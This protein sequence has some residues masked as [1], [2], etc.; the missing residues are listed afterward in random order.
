MNLYAFNPKNLNY[1]DSGEFIVRY[2][3]DIK[4]QK[5][6]LNVDLDFKELHTSIE[7][8]SVVFNKALAQIV[9][10]SE[11]KELLNLD[12]IRD[13]K[14]STIRTQLSVYKNSDKPAIMDAYGKIKVILKAYKGL[15]SKNYPT[16]TGGIISLITE[17]TNSSNKPFSD[18]LLLKDHIADLKIAND[19][20]V[21]KF[22]KRS[23][24]VIS[25]ETYNTK[26]LRKTI[27]DTYL[28]LVDYVL[29]LRKKNCQK[30][31]FNICIV[32]NFSSIK[33]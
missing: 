21:A 7:A 9:A 12:Q 24:E 18:L 19:N 6:D 3:T 32:N 30:T 28:E 17:L 33:T 31:Y 11:S 14:I 1:D 16:E 2:L 25:T 29:T 13:K 27:L 5:I 10:K 23:S 26:K 20:F 4:N 15:E 22:N 8:Q